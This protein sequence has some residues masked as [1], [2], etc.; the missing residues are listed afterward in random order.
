MNQELREFAFAASHDLR[1]PLRKIQTFCDLICSRHSKDMEVEG[2]RLFGR[3]QETGGNIT[4]EL[5][6]GFRMY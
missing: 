2:K 1:E 3:M 5:Y 6:S 4:G